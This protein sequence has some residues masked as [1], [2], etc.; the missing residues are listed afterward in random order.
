MLNEFNSSMQTRSLIPVHAFFFPSWCETMIRREANC[1]CIFISTCDAPSHVSN[2]SLTTQPTT[3]GNSSFFFCL[4]DHHQWNRYTVNNY[5][6]R[7]LDGTCHGCRPTTVFVNT[8]TIDNG[9][10]SGTCIYCTYNAEDKRNIRVCW[11]CDWRRPIEPSF[12]FLRIYHSHWYARHCLLQLGSTFPFTKCPQRLKLEENRTHSC[13]VA[14]HAKP[15][16]CH[17]RTHRIVLVHIACPHALHC[18]SHACVTN[19]TVLSISVRLLHL[20]WARSALFIQ[21]GV[22]ESFK[23][24]YFDTDLSLSCHSNISGMISTRYPA[25]WIRKHF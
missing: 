8:M 19:T 14:S 22:G 13:R 21:S 25:E 20:P 12:Y 5:P 3:T 17:H 23:R 6:H 15:S 18:S 24:E 11:K 10:Y 4:Y 1:E 9:Q 16:V 2:R 7:K